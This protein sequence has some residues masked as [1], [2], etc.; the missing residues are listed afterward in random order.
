MEDACDYVLDSPVISRMHARVDQREDCFYLTD[1][2]STNGTFLNGS[3]LA[4]NRPYL[5][6]EGDEVMLADLK[7]LFQ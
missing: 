5:L 6:K 7:F 2:R 1:L 4:A 3:R